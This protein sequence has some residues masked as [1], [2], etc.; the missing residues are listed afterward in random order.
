[1]KAYYERYPRRTW[2]LTGAIIGALVGLLIIGNFGV[3]S[4]GRG[5]AVWGWLFGAGLGAYVGF[6][7]GEWRLRKQTANSRHL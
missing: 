2:I 6:R 3:A 1:M 4:A 5:H 7:V